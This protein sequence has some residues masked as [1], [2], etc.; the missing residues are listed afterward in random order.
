MRLD[1]TVPPIHDGPRKHSIEVWCCKAI[2]IR[3]RLPPAAP[4]SRPGCA[5]SSPSS[6]G[7]RIFSTSAT[8]SCPTLPFNISS[9][10]SNSFARVPLNEQSL[11]LVKGA[12]YLGHHL[13]DGGDAL[14]AASLRLSCRSVERLAAS[15]NLRGDGTPAHASDHAA[16][17]TRGLDNRPYACVSNWFSACGLV[18]REIRPG[19]RPQRAPWIFRKNP[20][21]FGGRHKPA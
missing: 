13:L 15:E 12:A 21:G 2:S 4:R 17:V 19:D 9:L 8:A 1:L 14:S 6:G 16:G 20:E 7:G 5:I 18:S 10:C 11:S 3:W